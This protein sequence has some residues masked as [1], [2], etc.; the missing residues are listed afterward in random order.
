MLLPEQASAA[1]TMSMPAI[2][3]RRSL[4]AGRPR[5]G[6]AS[7]ADRVSTPGRRITGVR[8][9]GSKSK[10]DPGRPSGV[11][12]GAFPPLSAD[13][14]PTDRQGSNPAGARSVAGGEFTVG[15]SYDQRP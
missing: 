13:A 7:R 12:R 6:G 4:P 1:L 10:A 11:A 3:R 15:A 2:E 5:L 9:P 14:R 8:A